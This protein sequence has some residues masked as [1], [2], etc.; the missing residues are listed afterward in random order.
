VLGTSE[1]CKEKTM[2]ANFSKGM[3]VAGAA[4]LV[5]AL[6]L[7]ACSTPEAAEE[8]T[9]FT[10][11]GIEW[12][13]TSVTDQ[14]SGET[15]DVPNPESYFLIFNDDGT[16]EG[17]ADCNGVGGEY[18]YEEGGAFSLTLGP[19]TL[20]YCG[21]ESMDQQFVELLGSVAAGGPR[22]EGGLA[23]E[24]AGG[25]QRMIFQNGGGAAGT[26]E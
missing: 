6:L 22:G 11:T 10:L 19:S 3:F 5:A 21:D 9:E 17:K 26:A 13:W 1:S 23:L 16:F 24:S 15:T 25:A 7:A 20:L 18:T 8:T 14:S 12:Q 4:V 2:R